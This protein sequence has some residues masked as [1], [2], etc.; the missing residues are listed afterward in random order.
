MP[1]KTDPVEKMVTDQPHTILGKLCLGLTAGV[2]KKL[3]TR[4]NH[5]RQFQNQDIHYTVSLFFS[6]DRLGTENNVTF[7]T[8]M[9]LFDTEFT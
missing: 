8:G 9:S 5:H 7:T 4:E 1:L 3:L 2:N 6:F